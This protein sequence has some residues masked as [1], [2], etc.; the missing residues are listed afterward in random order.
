MTWGRH[1]W[2]IALIVI[3]LIVLVPELIAL[4]TNPKNTLSD[5][6]R[7]ELNLMPHV[8]NVHTAA[9]WLSLITFS[10]AVVVLILHI[11]GNQLG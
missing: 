5:Y 4:A 10:L 9:W 6:A 1:Y 7:Y 11:W 8:Y 2:P 3:S